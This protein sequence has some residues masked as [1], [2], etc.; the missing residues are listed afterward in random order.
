MFRIDTVHSLGN[1]NALS[2][3]QG[4]PNGCATAVSS[5]QKSRSRNIKVDMMQLV[6]ELFKKNGW[7]VLKFHFLLRCTLIHRCSVVNTR[8]TDGANSISELFW[9]ILVSVGNISTDTSC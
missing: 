4:S 7:K 2:E 8:S 6:L 1:K 5:L 3:C 9:L